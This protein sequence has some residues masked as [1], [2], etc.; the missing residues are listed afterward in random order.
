MD[1]FLSVVHVVGAVFIV[2]PMAILPMTGLRALRTGAATS[3][4][5]LATSTTVFSGISVIIALIGFA[6]VGLAPAKYDL[7]VT[8]PWVL[9]SIV[10]YAIA[11]VLSLFLVA[12]ALRGGAERIEAGTD[13]GSAR[14]RVAAGSGIAS[15]LLLVVVVLMVAKP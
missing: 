5:T 7:R 8:T 2:G 10:L 3:A 11:L 6:L 14:A 1:T 4:R 12:P 9:W 15:V 13:A